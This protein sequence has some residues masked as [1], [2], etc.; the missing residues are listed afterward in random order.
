MSIKH[1]LLF[2]ALIACQETVAQDYEK[3]DGYHGVGFAKPNDY[4][5]RV[6]IFK[7][8]N[9]AMD[10]SLVNKFPEPI[11]LEKGNYISTTGVF[12]YAFSVNNKQHIYGV[13]LAY[14]ISDSSTFHRFYCQDGYPYKMQHFVKNKIIFDSNID[15]AVMQS[16]LYDDEGE[17]QIKRATF[18]DLPVGANSI[19]TFYFPN[20][21]YTVTDSITK[22]ETRHYLDGDRRVKDLSTKEVKMYKNN[23]L[24]THEYERDSL[25]VFDTY[26][27]N[28]ISH[29]LEKKIGFYKEYHF[30]NGKLNFAKETKYLKN[31]KVITSYDKYKI[32]I[33]RETR[34]IID[35]GKTEIKKYDEEG[36]LYS[37]KIQKIEMPPQIKKVKKAPPI[38]KVKKD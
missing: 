15:S 32:V 1:L 25:K 29:R 19:D 36:R 30:E 24:A 35:G 3:L 5:N 14:S 38:K 22:I 37:T 20:G 16:V 9:K 12:N 34:T 31:G 4:W 18:R 13:A 10:V 21:T 28:K 11:T 2:F 17:V 27:D 6:R 26:S 7:Y 8:S 33:A 23:M